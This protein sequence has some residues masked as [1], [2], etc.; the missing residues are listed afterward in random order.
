MVSP[1]ITF[2]AGQAKRT[3]RSNRRV[4]RKAEILGDVLS[5]YPSNLASESASV[6][7]YVAVLD[8]PSLEHTGWLSVERR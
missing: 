5:S 3:L 8:P 4:L 1:E 2:S 6:K 7:M